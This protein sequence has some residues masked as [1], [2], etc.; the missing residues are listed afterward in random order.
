MFLKRVAFF[1][2]LI[3][4][5]N[6]LAI[7]PNI[8]TDI[9]GFI[10]F[11]TFLVCLFGGKPKLSLLLLLFLL[12]CVISILAN[13]IPAYFNSEQRLAAF[14]FVF[15]CISPFI[16]TKKLGVLRQYLFKYS[17]IFVGMVVVIS[18]IGKATGIYS[19]TNSLGLFQGITVHSML[20]GPL[21]AMTLVISLWKIS[22]LRKNPKIRNRYI[23]LAGLA[24][25]CLILAASRGALIGAVAG[26]LFMYAAIYKHRLAKQFKT[27]A[28][29]VIVLVSTSGLWSN[30]TE[31]LTIKNEESENI[32]SSREELWAF[33]IQEF[34]E[35]P[36]FGIG[37]ASSKY[38]IFNTVD[39]QLEPGTSWGAIFAQIG[40]IGGLAFLILILYY[41]V[42]LFKSKDQ[43]NNGALLL[44]LLVFFMM[45]WFAEG[46]ILASGD[47]IFYNSWLLLGI[48]GVYKN[49]NERFQ[50]RSIFY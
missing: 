40:I 11:I 24:F 50:N 15:A 9:R 14:I 19:G 25:I 1:L 20:L 49:N 36:I 48:I 21:A 35:S 28:L 8:P 7:T 3:A 27:I 37:F 39:G 45:H 13:D 30:Y 26:V 41:C 47:F 6:A 31:Q 2:A 33:R 16:E 34:Q 18:I 12:T 32:T 29:L 42:F 44:G 38:G 43:F 4:V 22:N 46:Y 23:L 17:M 5:N 10:F